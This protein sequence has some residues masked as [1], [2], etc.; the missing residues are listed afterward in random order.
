MHLTKLF[1]VAALLLAAGQASAQTPS[2]FFDYKDKIRSAEMIGPLPADAFGEQISLFNGDTEFVATDVDLPGNNDLPVRL[3][4]RLRVDVKSRGLS[5]R[6]VSLSPTPLGGFG[7]WDIDVPYIHATVDATYGWRSETGYNRCSGAI[8]PSVVSSFEVTEIFSG[9]QLHIPWE[10]GQELTNLAGHPVPQDGHSYRW[11]TRNH[12]R[13]RCIGQVQNYPGEG[14]LVVDPRGVKYTFDVAVLR[15][16]GA[17][18][19]PLSAEVMDSTHKLKVYLFVSRIE[20]R[21]GNFVTY[22]YSGERLTRISSS[23]GREI[24]LTWG[25]SS[26]DKVVAH[27][28]E[29]VY[30]YGPTFSVRLPD[31]S[32]WQYRSTGDLAVYPAAF[33]DSTTGDGRCIESLPSFASDFTLGVTHPAGSTA[34]FS[35]SY[36]AHR[37]SGTP[38]TACTW[39]YKDS[40]TGRDVYT[41]RIP[42]Y[43]HTYTIVRKEV[44]GPGIAPLV[45][46]Y[47]Y[48]PPETGRATF[49]GSAPYCLSCDKDKSTFVVNPDGSEVEHIF[50]ALWLHNEGVP[51]GTRTRNAAGQVVREEML[52]Y[53][54]DDEVSNYPFKPNFGEFTASDNYAVLRNRPQKVRTISQDGTV[55]K[56]VVSAYDQF[57]RPTSV[58]K[59][60]DIPASAVRTEQTV[61]F[62]SLPSWTL[63]QTS[64]VTVNGA[65]ASEIS[66]DATYVLPTVHKQFGRTVHTLGYDTTSTV[67][68]GQRATLRTITDGNGKVTTLTSWKRGIPQQV[69]FPGTPEATAGATRSA[70]VNDHGWITSVTDENG[71]STA[72]GYDPMGRLNLID[73]PNG[74]SV[75]WHNTVL[76]FEP[77]ASAEYGI[78]A[79]HWRQTISTG[80]ARKVSYFDALWRPLVVREYDSAN[81]SGTQRF[82]RM[83]YDHEGRTTFAS[84]PGTTDALTA[85]TRTLYDALGRVT[86]VR[87][88]SE[89]GVLV[90]KTEYLTGADGYFARTRN[91]RNYYTWTRFQAF[92]EPDYQTPV[93]SQQHSSGGI[94]YAVTEI[95]RDVFGKPRSIT[96]RSGDGAVTQTRS[97][98]YDAYQQLCKAV[99]PETGATIM[100]YD[101]AGNLAWSRSG[102]SQTSTTSC[103]TA[104]IPAAQRTTRTYD[105]RNRLLTLSFPDGLG[106]QSWTYT[107]DGL[108]ASITTNNSNG[109]NAVTNSYGYNRRRL[110]ESET[111]GVN[112]QLWGLGYAYDRN[113]NPSGHTSA[114]GL[115]VDYAPNALGQAT[116]AGGYATAVTYFP[117]GAIKQFTYGNGLK[118]TLSQNA[119]GLPD[120]SCDFAGSSCGAAAVLNDGYDYDPNG[121][122]AA[123]SDGRT[124]GRGHRTMTYD[125]L[126]RLTGTVSPMFG[127]ANYG[128]DVLDNLRT[129]QVTAGPRAR[130][131]TYVYDAKHRLTNVTNTSSNATVIGLG[132]DERGNVTNK[133]GLQLAFD[134]GNRLREAVGVE[135]YHYDGHGRRVL[136]VRDGRNLYSVYGQD[137]TL[138]FQRDE[139]SGKTLDYVHLG[140]SLVAQ[141]ENA[142]AVST[143]VL[144]VPGGSATGS[145]T[146]SW[147]AV[148]I[149]SKFQLQ[150]RLGSGSWSTIHDAAALSK[151]VSGKAAGTWGYRVRACTATT[152]GSWSAEKTVTVQLP[153]TTA[154]TL[155]VP[156]TSTTGSYTV[157]WTAVTGATTYELEEAVN[158][159]GYSALPSVGA[160]S[161][162]ITGRQDGT[163][164]Y[165]VRGCNPAGCGPYSAAKATQVTL[166]PATVP[167]VTVPA[168]SQ[169]GAYTASWTSVAGSTRYELEERLG[170]GSWAKIHDAAATS[171]AVSGKSTGSWGYRARACNTSCGAWSAVATVQVTIPPAVPTLTAPATSSTGSYSVSWTTVATATSYEL[172]ERQ[173]SGAWSS[174]QNTS[175]T[176]R[177]IT[178]KGN[179]AWG[180]QVRACIG[181]VCSAYSAAKTV[182]VT[183]PPTAVPVLTVPGQGLN[184]SYTVSWT[185]VSAATSYQLQERLGSGSWTTVHDG[186]ATS[187]AISGKAAGSWGYQVRACNVGG[188]AAWSAVKS[189]TVIHP[190][191]GPPPLTVP[192]NNATGS[193]SVT[194]T[195]VATATRYELQERSGTGSWPAPIHN[196]TGTSKAV[197]NKATGSWGYR[198]RACN[199]AGCSAYS[200]EKVVAVL[201]APSGV[202]TLTVPVTNTTGSYTVSWTAVATATSYELQERL[203]TGSWSAVQNTS[204]LNRAFSGKAGGSWGYQVR[205]CNTS[206]CGGWSAA[207]AILVAPRTPAITGANNHRFYLGQSEFTSCVVTWSSVA[208]ADSYQLESPAGMRMY[209]GTAQTYSGVSPNCSV[210][211]RIR[212]CNG[213]GCSAW[214]PSYEPGFTSD[215]PPT[216]GN[217]GDPPMDP[218]RVRQQSPSPTAGG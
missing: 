32:S 212:A 40:I 172:Q 218:L 129:V 215:P 44:T 2:S 173:G 86:E 206:G 179:G 122:V 98:V 3:G 23:D 168:T 5:S 194:W 81:V 138:R 175:A 127:T 149:A 61:F 54:S 141:V 73:Y 20:D 83:A 188:C 132:Y 183:L 48:E 177:S 90:T 6:G 137:G 197:S 185:S 4:R 105:G 181:S 108:P 96:R 30:T 94:G 200:A 25:A 154:P 89:L 151:A 76:A 49:P 67:A 112:G 115:A 12:Y 51:L 158:G 170:S 189:T 139:R 124:G 152:C 50:G 63:G 140:G 156:T 113:G 38:A 162:A 171:R 205:A 144:T 36:G 85:G 159:G 57:A 160:V 193:Y 130:N 66:Y 180:Y 87:Q 114:G 37:R 186:A 31:G 106:N 11:G 116:K 167:T 191:A 133:N 15:E 24:S 204:A 75:D 93:F 165:R 161:L 147:T 153:P 17:I 97:Y 178:G 195:A 29:W 196:G 119:R 35:F 88:D 213:A 42:D 21:F 84:Y 45:W 136:S 184:G 59:S 72:Y 100:A 207:K 169:T 71:F 134:H 209:D 142:I 148:A 145:Y 78:D 101:N 68:S 82:T 110:L 80:N 92:D 121:N 125:P 208:G 65:V 28:R 79:G 43:A 126:D 102:A 7:G 33:D 176:S 10:G 202:P 70:V 16:A 8:L 58:A 120:T 199:D 74:D 91:P 64:R 128:Y 192:A 53:V 216:P 174:I 18:E 19:K 99:E 187:K 201:R 1:A 77:V 123:I 103:N 56:S 41:L 52:T 182:T 55:F 190:P 166:P 117:N 9:I 14:F 214:S 26:I 210:L 109:A 163:W 47:G 155:T 146:V 157:S 95:D 131:H 104:D 39:L 46:S 164:S 217:P 107:K 62:D 150:E 60:N 27:G 198:I 135:Q 22:H 13:A 118:H 111:F 69:K 211:Y 34:K 143:P 203:G